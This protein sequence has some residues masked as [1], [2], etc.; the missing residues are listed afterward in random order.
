MNGSAEIQVTT[1]GLKSSK[2]GD[3]LI[4]SKSELID[5]ATKSDDIKGVMTKKD[6]MK[7]N[8]N[9]GQ[10]LFGFVTERSK[11]GPL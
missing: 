8:I 10:C 4:V 2:E 9:Q 3:L 5:P 1:A 11:R 6:W 7:T